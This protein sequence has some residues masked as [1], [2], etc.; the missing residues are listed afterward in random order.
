MSNDRRTWVPGLCLLAAVL[1]FVSGSVAATGA[2]QPHQSD[3]TAAVYTGQPKAPLSLADV[4]MSD[5]VSQTFEF[6]GAFPTGWQTYDNITRSP[7]SVYLLTYSW[8]TTDYTHAQGTRS[9]TAVGPSAGSVFLPEAVYS[10]A[11]DSWL[12]FPV[13]LTRVWQAQMDFAYLSASAM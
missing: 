1:L 6:T 12:V 11:V 13:D 10:D 3:L 4:G 8:S 2:T 9:A 5:I 7:G